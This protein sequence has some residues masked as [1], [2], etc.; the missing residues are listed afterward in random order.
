[1]V[2]PAEFG[3]RGSTRASRPP[4]SCPTQASPL[5][6][7]STCGTG[8]C[9]DLAVTPPCGAP[10]ALLSHAGADAVRD[11]AAPVFGIGRARA[12]VLACGAFSGFWSS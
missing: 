11:G 7:A 1:M 3:R 5:L 8:R 4:V 6:V 12:L 9:P 10:V 2:G